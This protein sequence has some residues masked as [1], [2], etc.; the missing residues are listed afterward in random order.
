MDGHVGW[1]DS[2][3]DLTLTVVP[4]LEEVRSILLMARM[5]FWQEDHFFL[6][7]HLFETLVHKQIV[8]LMHCAVATLARSTKDLE[9]SSESKL[10]KRFNKLFLLKGDD[11]NGL[12]LRSYKSTS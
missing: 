10:E 3:M 2:I 4:F 12:T 7:F 11:E 8:F 6:E 1:P 5:N 9:T